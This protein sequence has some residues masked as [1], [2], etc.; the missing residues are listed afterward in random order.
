MTDASL[1]I[2]GAMVTLIAGTG[3]WLRIYTHF[4]REWMRQNRETVETTEEYE[5][6]SDGQ[7]HAHSSE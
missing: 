7:S 1:F 5:A 6:R 3:F 2:F 4:R